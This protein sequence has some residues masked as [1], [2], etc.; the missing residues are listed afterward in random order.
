MKE[1]LRVFSAGTSALVWITGALRPLISQARPEHNSDRASLSGKQRRRSGIGCLNGGIGVLVRGFFIWSGPR[2]WVGQLLGQCFS[3][4]LGLTPLEVVV[5]SHNGKWKGR[6]TG[7]LPGTIERF[8]RF[9]ELSAAT[10]N[11]SSRSV[12]PGDV[13]F[14]NSHPA[15]H[16]YANNM[17]NW[18]TW[19]FNLHRHLWP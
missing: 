12:L 11:Y 16:C 17:M 8:G 3:F 5:S 10:P 9:M 4:F 18:K 6:C 1:I 15:K 14:G 19:R 13:Y 7:A 2:D